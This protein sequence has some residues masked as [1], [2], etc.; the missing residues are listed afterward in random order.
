[1]SHPQGSLPSLVENLVKNW[2][3]EASFKPKLSDWRTIDQ[4]KYTFAM[5]GGAPQNGEHMVTVGTYNAIITPNEYYS[6]EHSDFAA[7]HKAFKRMM[8]MFAWEVLEVYSYVVILGRG[9]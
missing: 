4:E 7:S 8:P 9:E 6:P 5:N 2:E 3:I 1:M